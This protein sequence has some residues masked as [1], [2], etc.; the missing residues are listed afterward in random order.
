MNQNFSFSSSRD[1]SS[2]SISTHNPIFISAPIVSSRAVQDNESLQV[3]NIR[4]VVTERD[5][6]CLYNLY[7]ISRDMFEVSPS[8]PNI[9]VDD[10]VHAED[11]IIVYEEQLKAGLRFP[12]GPF[13]GE[14]LAIYK[15]SIAQLHLIVSASC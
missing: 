10:H 5:V 7:Q 14:I 8:R 4:S 2:T 9:H 12:I 13:Y 3:S 15:L 6:N 1:S 11:M